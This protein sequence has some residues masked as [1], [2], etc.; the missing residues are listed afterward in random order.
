MLKL[1]REYLLALNIC[2]NE[3]NI[4]K[5]KKNIFPLRKYLPNWNLYLF[6]PYCAAGDGTVGLAHAGEGFTVSY[7]L[8]PHTCLLFINLF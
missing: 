5:I 4:F 8:S 2:N 7:I 6:V 1:L 3:S